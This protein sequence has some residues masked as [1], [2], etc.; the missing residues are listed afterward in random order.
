MK[1]VKINYRNKTIILTIAELIG[2]KYYTYNIIPSSM[3]IN[4]LF[5]KNAHAPYSTFQDLKPVIYIINDLS[6]LFYRTWYYNNY[7]F[8]RR[9]YIYIYDIYEN[10]GLMI[11]IIIIKTMMF[12]TGIEYKYN[13]I[14]HAKV[15]FFFL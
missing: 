9:R 1:L 10:G 11:I 13:I 15:L 4:L 8:P 2:R 7:N 3:K 5:K 12:C 6:I 14:F